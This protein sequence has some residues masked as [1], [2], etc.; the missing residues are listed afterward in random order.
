MD[1]QTSLKQFN[2]ESNVPI[3]TISK[4]L[5]RHKFHPYKMQIKQALAEDD[6][7]R[8]IQFCELMIER[9]AENDQLLKNI[10]FSDESTF[11]LNGCVNKHNVRYWSDSN[12]YFMREGHTQRPQKV[13]V[14]AG[15]LGDH[16]IGPLFID[17][18]L[19]ADLYLELLMDTIDPLITVL[20]ENSR[21]DE[22]N[23]EFDIDNIF[24]QQDGCPAHYARHV[25]TYLDEMYPNRWI[26]RRGL[27]EWPARSPDLAPN[28]FFLWGY[29][30]LVVYKTIPNSI[31]DLKAR[32]TAAVGTYPGKHFG[33]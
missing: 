1:G 28:D 19:T 2:N 13:N 20:V 33:T 18:N 8:R 4:I 11:F 10:C 7:D 25:R 23:L 17:A 29:L 14:W 30:K 24:F 9:I 32:I 22:G 27:I 5:K 15:I 3:N 16:V 21:N 26:G 12:P 6:F 31:E